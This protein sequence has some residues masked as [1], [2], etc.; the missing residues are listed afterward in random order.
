MSTAALLP[1]DPALSPEQINRIL[2]IRTNLLPAEVTA[3]RNARR[4]RVVLAGVLVLVALLTGG[5][6][7]QADKQRDQV[8][9]ELAEVTDQVDRVRAQTEKPEFNKVTS[10]ITQRD[11]ITTDLKSALKKD[12][13]WP[14][15]LDSLRTRAADKGVTLDSLNGALD[16][17]STLGVTKTSDTVGTLMLAGTAK[18]KPTIAGFVD[19]VA[20]VNGVTDVYLTAANEQ[21]KNWAFT[22]SASIKSSLLT[23]GGK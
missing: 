2:P 19:A 15:L 22:L 7:V 20:K 21:E 9:V 4:T 23:N 13:P 16:D 18:D 1:L 12:L 10:T 14:T 6:Y 11:A 3:G 17:D 8:D 5:W